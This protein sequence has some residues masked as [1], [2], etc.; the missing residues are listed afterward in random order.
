[1]LFVR[2]L[3]KRLYSSI[4][5]KIYISQIVIILIPYIIFCTYFYQNIQQKNKSRTVDILNTQATQIEFDIRQKLSICKYYSNFISSSSFVMKF[6]DSYSLNDYTKVS[7]IKD[8]IVPLTEMIRTQNQHIASIVIIHGNVTLFDSKPYLVMDPLF[9]DLIDELLL[10]YPKS[11][12]YGSTLI[13]PPEEGGDF[14]LYSPV[15]N[16]KLDKIIGLIKME[17]IPGDIFSMIDNTLENTSMLSI[18]VFSDHNNL[19]LYS[20]NTSVVSDPAHTFSMPLPDICSYLEISIASE[21]SSTE[22]IVLLMSLFI[23]FVTLGAVSYLFIKVMLKKLFILNDAMHSFQ[24]EEQ[25]NSISFNSHDEIGVLSRSFVNMIN[26]IRELAIHVDELH[27]LEQEAIYRSLENQLNPHFLINA[28][29]MARMNALVNGDNQTSDMLE[30]IT[31]YYSYNIRNKKKT[32]RFFDELQNVKNYLE[33]Y[34][35]LKDRKIQLRFETFFGQEQLIFNTK[36]LKFTFQP[37]VE[38]AVIHGFANMKENRLVR[39]DAQITENKLIIKIEDNGCGMKKSEVEA[40]K[41][42][43]FY[44]DMNINS[45]DIRNSSIGLRNIHSRIV[46]SYGTEYG[47]DIY[48]EPGLGTLISVVLPVITCEGGNELETGFN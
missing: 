48:S 14:L 21:S 8:N 36:I 2:N 13:I 12:S 7:V 35:N 27:R 20:S 10:E 44:S 5:A 3:A 45:P 15:Y 11:L 37:I 42:N 4:L 9:N 38:N 30:R 46:L 22:Y 40:L 31:Q 1:M 39:I 17:I 29:D 33:I 19:P 47:L 41:Q 24:N 28:L 26:R 18:S 25:I 6:L 16:T 34:S 43:L 32:I 23:A